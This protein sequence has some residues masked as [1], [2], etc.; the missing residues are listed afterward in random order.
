MDVTILRGRW[1]KSISRSGD[2]D[3]IFAAIAATMIRIDARGAPGII[4][5]QNEGIHLIASVRPSH[6]L[7]AEQSAGCPF[8]I[9]DGR[10][11]SSRQPAAPVRFGKRHGES[12]LGA[13]L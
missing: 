2:I 3:K 10:V 6:T 5:N 8:S 4:P 13:G 9:S 1:Y 11:A 7:G 12:F